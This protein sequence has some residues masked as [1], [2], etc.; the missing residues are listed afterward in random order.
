MATDNNGDGSSSSADSAEEVQLDAAAL[1]IECAFDVRAWDDLV[2]AETLASLEAACAELGAT[3]SSFWVGADGAART[4]LERF[5]LDV[6]A[7]HMHGR[8][9]AECDL[10]RSGVEFWAQRRSSRSARAAQSINWHFDKDEALREAHG[11]FVHPHISTVT[12]LSDAGA[13]TVVMPVRIDLDGTGARL[14]A[15]AASASCATVSYP[16][17]GRHLAFN[18]RLLHGCPIELAFQRVQSYE[19]RT[20]LV[21]IWLN[22]R[23]AGIE[24]AAHVGKRARP[25]ASSSLAPGQPPPLELRA[26]PGVAGAEGLSA[27][28]AR[29]SAVR[30]DF[31]VGDMAHARVSVEARALRRLFGEGAAAAPPVVRVHAEVTLDVGEPTSE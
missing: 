15:P 17:R 29:A 4:P 5:A 2:P 16:R 6:W 28:R 3:D 24:T 12:Y 22:H 23:P 8:T 1:E 31:P 30:L 25:P 21:N 7:F 19:R 9:P 11:V 20:V 10:A 26:L 18:G 14:D 13:P 27:A